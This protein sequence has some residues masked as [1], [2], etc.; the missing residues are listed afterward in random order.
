MSPKLVSSSEA[1]RQ[2]G[3][4]RNTLANW[5]RQGKV[6]PAEVTA[7]GQARWDVED[8]REQLRALRRGGSAR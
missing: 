1:A 8:L 6:S 7:G 4:H 2:L 5:W 3:V